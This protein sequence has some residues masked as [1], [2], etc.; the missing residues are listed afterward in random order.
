VGNN[1]MSAAARLV[2]RHS[3]ASGA[4]SRIA[5][6]LRYA[7]QV[8]SEISST[9]KNILFAGSSAAEKDESL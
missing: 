2:R 4:L 9:S 6:V 8:K 3:R 1:G 7:G 5:L